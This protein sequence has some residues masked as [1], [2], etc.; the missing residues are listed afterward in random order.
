MIVPPDVVPSRDQETRL[1][2]AFQRTRTAAAF[3]ALYR[4]TSPGLLGVIEHLHVQQRV[5][6]DPLDTLQDTFVNV[7]R[8]AGSFRA[9]ASG[10]FR[11]W[12]RTIAANAIRRARRRP[13]GVG[14]LFSEVDEALPDPSDRSAGPVRLTADA[15]S[16]LDLRAAYAILLLQ[17]AAAYETLKERDRRALE[18]VE[19]EGLSYAEVG[20]RLRVGRSNTK[21]IVF[22]ARQRLR[23][24]MTAAFAAGDGEPP[25]TAD[26]RVLRT[27]SDAA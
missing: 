22:R 25:R 12:A 10:G 7:Y 4:A 21:M 19:V 8:Y 17:Y 13:R 2:A 26:G 1:M 15:E 6:A 9:D 23:N 11:A 20:E 24:A 3:E 14:V 27:T 16:T 18:L 5:A